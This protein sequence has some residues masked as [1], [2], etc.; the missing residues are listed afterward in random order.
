MQIYPTPGMHTV[1]NMDLFYVASSTT[2]RTYLFRPSCRALAN[3][4]QEPKLR[5]LRPPFSRRNWTLSISNDLHH[6]PG[7]K[8]SES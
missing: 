3:E 5:S 7:L 6:Y 8:Y 2:A 4:P 1:R